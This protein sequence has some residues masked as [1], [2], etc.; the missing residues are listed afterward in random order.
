M[1]T[2]SLLLC[3]R[4]LEGIRPRSSGQLARGRSMSRGSY[5]MEVISCYDRRDSP[6]PFAYFPPRMWE[7]LAVALL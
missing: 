2:V 5:R 4:G 1:N 3:F 6:S 7:V